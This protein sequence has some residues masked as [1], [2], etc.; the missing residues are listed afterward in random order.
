MKK[1][2]EVT[3]QTKENLKNAFWKIYRKKSIEKISV[4]EITD[5]AGYN[6]GTFYLYYK[7]IYQILEEI[8]RGLLAEDIADVE[9]KFENEEELIAGVIKGYEKNKK[10]MDVLLGEHGD[11]AFQIRWKLQIKEIMRRKL[12]KKGVACTPEIEYVLE[13]HMQGAIAATQ[14]WFGN[15]KDISFEE[16]LHLL[17][18]E[19]NLLGRFEKQKKAALNNQ[20]KIVD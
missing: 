5:A 1:Q 4:K 16:L 8:E 9:M 19:A 14:L 6:R 10:Y 11:P 17:F 20:E 12:L 3:K 13:Y 2:P 18:R 7:D 15:K